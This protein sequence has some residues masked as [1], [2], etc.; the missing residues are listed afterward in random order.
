LG[1][2]A[3]LSKRRVGGAAGGGEDLQEVPKEPKELTRLGT[4][5]GPGR[6]GVS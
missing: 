1:R 3:E 5:N 4:G 2:E 6:V